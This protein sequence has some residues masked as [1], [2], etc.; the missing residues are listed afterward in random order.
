MKFRTDFVTN[1]S[2]SSFVI[3]AKVNL[4]D[5]LK[6]YMADEYGKYGTKLLDEHLMTSE[7]VLRDI[8]EDERWIND[9]YLGNYECEQI[10]R[11]AEDDTDSRYLFAEVYI[12]DTEGGVFPE[13]ALWLYT[14]IPTAYKDKIF[15]TEPNY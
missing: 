3:C 14:H 8:D 13:D 1:S 5:S 11:V 4:C 9:I 10:K 12:E 15:E 6:S 7:E 2:S